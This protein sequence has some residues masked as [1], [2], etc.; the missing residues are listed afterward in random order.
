M[1]SVPEACIEDDLI[2]VYQAPKRPRRVLSGDEYAALKGA[3][4]TRGFEDIPALSASECVA[5]ETLISIYTQR[6]VH[7]TKQSHTVHKRK[8]ATYWK[9]YQQGQ[10][11]LQIAQRVGMAPTLLVRNMLQLVGQEGLDKRDVSRI[12][13]NVTLYA[14]NKQLREQ[15]MECMANDHVYSPFVDRIKEHVGQE[16]E[17]YLFQKL[18][19]RGLQFRTEDEMRADGYA[20]TPDVFFP[21]PHQVTLAS[22]EKVVALWLDSK[23]SFG[24]RSSLVQGLREQMISYRMRFGPGVIIFWFGHVEISDDLELHKGRGIHITDRFPIQISPAE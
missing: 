20:K 9:Q 18:Q 5:Y 21:I 11:M 8:M 24:D 7:K 12:L 17:Y 14:P 6:V 16:W 3:F 22:G 10:T 23:A 4:A 2:A 13:K 15:I 19:R 1:A